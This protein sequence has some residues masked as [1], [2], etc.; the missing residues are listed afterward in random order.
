MLQITIFFLCSRINKWSNRNTSLWSI[1]VNAYGNTNDQTSGD[2]PQ[3][4]IRSKTRCRTLYRLI[5]VKN[6]RMP[7]ALNLFRLISHDKIVMKS[8]IMKTG[9]LYKKKRVKVY[10]FAW[11]SN[12]QQ[13]FD[14]NIR[15]FA[16]VCLIKITKRLSRLDWSPS[17]IRFWQ[18]IYMC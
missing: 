11:W 4:K 7:T 13:L 5:K 2:R 16:K 17:K 9:V 8:W 1:T 6:V 10:N 12:M 14:A 3:R 18:K 15:M